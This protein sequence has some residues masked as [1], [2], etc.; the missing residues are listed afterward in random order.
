MKKIGPLTAEQVEELI[1]FCKTREFAAEKRAGAADEPGADWLLADAWALVRVKIFDMAA[2]DTLKPAPISDATLNAAN[3]FMTATRQMPPLKAWADPEGFFVI[4]WDYG[5]GR[6]FTLKVDSVGDCH[7]A[8][9][10]QGQRRCGKYSGFIPTE[11]ME[12]VTLAVYGA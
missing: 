1:V 8:A 3:A 10:A 9:V 2:T 12:A 4:E 5:P 7:W 11:V 6:M